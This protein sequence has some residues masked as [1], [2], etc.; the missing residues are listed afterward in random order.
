MLGVLHCFGA[1]PRREAR[2]AAPPQPPPSAEAPQRRQER[3]KKHVLLLQGDLVGSLSAQEELE[4]RGK[5]EMLCLL[6]YFFLPPCVAQAGSTLSS[7]PR[8]PASSH[9]P[10]RLQLSAR[11]GGGCSEPRATTFIKKI[12]LC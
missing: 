11:Q 5:R 9:E 7:V 1:L 12:G 2:R 6:R 10:L 3:G 4:L 8:L